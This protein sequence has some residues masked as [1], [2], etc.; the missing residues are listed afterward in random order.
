M[1]RTTAWVNYSK[2]LVTCQWYATQIARSLIKIKAGSLPVYRENAR[3]GEANKGQQ[4]NPLR[5]NDFLRVAPFRV[6][7]Q[8]T[9]ARA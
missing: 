7:S 5:R 3:A 4:T 8:T 1:L 6:V 2:T 9:L